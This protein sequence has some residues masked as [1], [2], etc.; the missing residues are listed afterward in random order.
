MTIRRDPYGLFG[1]YL[2]SLV[3]EYLEVEQC[4]GRAWRSDI[5]K[6]I[7]RLQESDGMVW[8][9]AGNSKPGAR[10]LIRSFQ[11]DAIVD[12]SVAVLILSRAA[13]YTRPVATLEPGRAQEIL[14]FVKRGVETDP[15]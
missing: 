14:D 11:N 4:A 7:E 15:K 8:T 1:V 10:P 5:E 6:C 12:T 9:G 13:R 2:Q 3:L